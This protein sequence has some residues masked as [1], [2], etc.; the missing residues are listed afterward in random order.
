M[1]VMK[2][3]LPLSVVLSV[4]P[5]LV[6]G[7]ALDAAGREPLRPP[8]GPA[9]H[10]APGHP[11]EDGKRS[12]ETEQQAGSEQRWLIR[13]QL[14]RERVL[15]AFTD[16]R[17]QSLRVWTTPTAAEL[18]VEVGDDLFLVDTRQARL[19]QMADAVRDQLAR[20]F[21]LLFAY[22]VPR[23]EEPRER[24]SDPVEI[25]EP[26]VE[27]RLALVPAENV[28]GQ[29][30]NPGDTR[31]PLMPNVALEEYREAWRVAFDVDDR[32]VVLFLDPP[33][34]GEPR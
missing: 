10:A 30:L 29:A 27:A 19:F 13:M 16:D 15:A 8:A 20:E 7:A 5:A 22:P 34:G 9:C 1:E 14:S 28:L 26:G 6:G 18:L 3:A 21:Q 31:L 24:P 2:L 17:R 11:I 4:V 33:A 32:E 12:V 25:V 23:V